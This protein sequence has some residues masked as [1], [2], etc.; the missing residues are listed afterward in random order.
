MRT[1]PD[2]SHTE[3]PQLDHPTPIPFH[4]P[5]Q[6]ELNFPC[7]PRGP[8]IARMTL[9]AILKAHGLTELAERAELL[10]SELATNSVRH[11]P[12]ARRPSASTGCTPYSASASGT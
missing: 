2:P 8:R 1:E 10:V 12:R 9:C 4:H 11:T 6:Y 7:A 5:W 3:Q